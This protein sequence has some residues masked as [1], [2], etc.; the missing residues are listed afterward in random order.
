ML[1]IVGTMI[2]QP[3]IKEAIVFCGPPQV[4][5]INLTGEE[6]SSVTIS[7]GSANRPVLNLKEGQ[8]ITVPIVGHFSECS[9]I[10]T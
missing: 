1:G 9:T 2:S 6:I 3:I 5:L 4:T 10:V 8:A 7:L